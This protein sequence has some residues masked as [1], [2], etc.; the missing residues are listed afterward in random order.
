MVSANGF[1]CLH[2]LYMYRP[3]FQPFHHCLNLNSLLNSSK[4]TVTF[5]S[6]S[7][8]M[9]NS[10]VVEQVLP[11]WGN[12]E[13]CNDSG[14]RPDGLTLELKQPEVV[15]QEKV[16]LN[17]RS[18]HFLEETDEEQLSKRILVLSRTNK[19][20]SALELLGSMELSGLHPNL[21][22]CNSLLSCLWR[23]GLI[24]DGLR[25]FEFMK[26]KKITTGHTYSLVLKAVADAKGCDTAL[27]MFSE[28][29]KEHEVEKGFDAIVYNTMISVCG[30]VNNWLESLRLWI[31]MKKNGHTGTRVTF[32]LLVSIFAR[33]GQNELAL[34][35]YGEMI[36]GEFEPGKDTMQAVI[37]A[38]AKEGKWEF[39]LSVFQSMLKKGLKPNTVA[40]NALI[41]SLGK[42]GEIKLAFKVFNTMKSLG[43]LPDTYTWN[44][45]LGA[46]YRAN[47]HDNA[48]RLF[49]SI[50]RDQDSQLNSHLYNNALISCSKLGLWERALQ[51][52]WQMETS[53]V[54]VSAASYNL[55]ISACEKAKKPD[56]AVQVYEHMVHQKCI[57]D[58]FTHLSLIRVCIWGSR[59]NEVEEILN[60]G[61]FSIVRS[62][63]LL[64]SFSSQFNTF[65]NSVLQVSTS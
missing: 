25:V 49:E 11:P 33:C 38:C 1:T 61:I 56:V 55:V 17:V 4:R 40:C 42:A 60:V 5:S 23:N 30:R 7:I 51:L 41:N 63:L 39:A 10:P 50:K 62:L 36:H 28:M 44:A 15:P 37:G 2:Q 32:C 14:F 57:P 43:H 19:V 20:R 54:P 34:D 13:T 27:K 26:T 65:L 52:L 53:G 58:T 64:K 24:D 46:L 6:G 45:I 9:N 8:K 48:L 16:M 18:V 12:S 21:H 31:S 47:R 35:A 29:E 22:A 59:W 3:H